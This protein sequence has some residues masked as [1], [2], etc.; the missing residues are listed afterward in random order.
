VGDAQKHSYVLTTC[1]R[2]R[3]TNHNDMRY[4]RW[5]NWCWCTFLTTCSELCQVRSSDHVTHRSVCAFSLRLLI[6]NAII[7]VCCAAIV[8][9]PLSSSASATSF[10]SLL[11]LAI[12]TF[13][14]V[15]QYGPSVPALQR[16]HALG[17]NVKHT[18][19]DLHWVSFPGGHAVCSI[20]TFQ[21]DCGPSTSL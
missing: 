1:R 15:T 4:W 19:D 5:C 14:Y 18:Y 17:F 2:L 20:F 3:V 21:V 7:N 6:Y 11:Y 8:I 13:L 10:P 16:Q 9:S 12:F